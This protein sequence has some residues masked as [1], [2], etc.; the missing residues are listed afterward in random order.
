MDGKL[1]L[2]LRDAIVLT[3]ENNSQ[4]RIQETQ[5]ESSKFTLLGAHAPFDPVVTSTDNIT[6]TISPPFTV[7]QGTGSS[8]VQFQ[9]HD[10]KSGV[11]LFTDLRNGNKR[12]IDFHQLASIPPI[13]PFY[14]F[15]P[16]PVRR[17]IFNSRSRFCSNGWFFANRAPLII[18]R[19]NFSSRKPLSRPK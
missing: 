14:L 12:S 5:V 11:W 19:R 16:T 17:S 3:L 15:N 18:A 9:E 13:I 4:V 8:N 6:S 10:E 1:R 2:S 7:L